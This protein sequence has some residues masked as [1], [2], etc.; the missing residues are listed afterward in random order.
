MWNDIKQIKILNNKGQEIPLGNIVDIKMANGLKKI[1][2][3]DGDYAISITASLKG[4]DTGTA[5][6]KAMEVVNQL[7]LPKDWKN[8]L[9]STMIFIVILK[10]ILPYWI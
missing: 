4:I 6:K 7:N 1:S 9:K 5:S 10:L 3:N 2:R 8:V